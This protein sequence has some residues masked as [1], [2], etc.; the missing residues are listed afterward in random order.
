[1]FHSLKQEKVILLRKGEKGIKI[2]LF[3]KKL[4]YVMLQEVGGKPINSCEIFA[5]ILHSTIPVSSLCIL[6]G[7]ALWYKCTHKSVQ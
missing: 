7:I 2:R 5:W 6:N 4:S 3:E 1:M